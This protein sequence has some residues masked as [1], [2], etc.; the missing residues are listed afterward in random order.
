MIRYS[1][2][3]VLLSLVLCNGYKFL[4]YSPIFGY[5]HTK[6][7]G[8]L[9]DALT[10]AG[11]DVTVLMPVVDIEEEHKTG[12][13]LTK[14]IIKIPA[15][16][17]ILEFLKNRKNV[18]GKMWTMKPGPVGLVEIVKAMSDAFTSQCEVVINDDELMKRLREEKFD[19]G[20]AETFS[21]C[22][23]G[24]FEVAK[25]P[26]SMAAFSGVHM[27][28]ISGAIGEPSFPS[29]VPGAMSTSSDHMS[30]MDRF[31]NVLELVLGKK[32]FHD[33]YD[34]E[35]AYF[36]EKFGPR[37]K[38]WQDLL[39]ETSYVMT[40]SN[41][42]LDYP[43]PTLHKTIFLGGITVPVNATKSP[44]S[45]EWNDILNRRKT[46]VLVSFGSVSKAIYMPDEYRVN[47]LKLF[48]SMPDTTFIMKYE[49]E[50][51][52][53][54]DHLPN[55]HLS[56]WFPQNTLWVS[57]PFKIPHK[58]DSRVT[59]FITHGG[60]GSIT[61]LAYAGKPAVLIPLFGDQSR[62]G[63]M[64]ARHGGAIVLSKHDLLDPAKLKHSL[65]EI[66]TDDSAFQQRSYKIT[67][68]H[69]YNHQNY[70]IMTRI[71]HPES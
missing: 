30:I 49:Q 57:R 12:L 22:G 48:K 2:L 53:M 6:F 51:S 41:P 15:N 23:F 54:A 9:A 65:E 47:L 1:F 8:T 36:R 27:D 33:I 19:V 58:S 66:F 61:E 4:V 3:L 63:L 18:L 40:N 67:V 43:R 42:Y 70:N 5:S 62:N 16:P 21:V 20:I 45:E 24:I 14:N 60:L 46:T 52:T 29:Y 34:T 55:V 68:T 50:N 28:A 44:L 35:I 31:M 32:F 13:K 37:F 39:A 17:R 64:L 7:M 59:A 38:H 25:I 69:T 11:H 26:A 10:E 71:I 56:T